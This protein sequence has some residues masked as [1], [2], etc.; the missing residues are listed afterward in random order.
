MAYHVTVQ[1]SG[2]QFDCE[3]DEAVL[4][5]ALRQGVT[6]NY[7]C[8]DGA[9]GSCMGKIVSGKVAYPDGTLPPAISQQ[10]AAHGHALFCQA[11]PRAD[12]V[13]EAKVVEQAGEIRVKTLPVRVRRIE[14]LTDDVMVL[15]LQLP[16]GERLQFKAGQWLEFLLKDGSRRAFSIANPPHDDELIEL[17][18]RYVEGGRFTEHV[19][20][21]L[22]EGALLRIEGPQ[23]TFV[24]R[25]DSPRPI[26][27]MAGGTGIAP[28]KGMIEHGFHVGLDQPMHLFWGVRARKDLYLNE[29]V[30]SWAAT[31]P[32]FRY[33]PV[34]S[35]PREDDA[36][37]GEVGLVHDALVRSYPDLSS[38]DVYMAGPPA[39]IE[40]AK[41]AFALHGLPDSQL[42][43]DSFEFGSDTLKAMADASPTG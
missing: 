21:K 6:L 25:E 17:H 12:L 29:L 9:C 22:K 36:W 1:P 13:I 20:H 26:L 39:M 8:R 33:T 11:R 41:Q 31:H 23:G 5:A 15:F 38:F 4:A 24:L 16:A 19:F 35:E 43:F 10:E 18:V 14:R 32:G 7:G 3:E 30:E 28:L 27:M 37:D 34:L 2:R 42:F 40:V